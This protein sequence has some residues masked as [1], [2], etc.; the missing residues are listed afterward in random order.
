MN[1]ERGP[2]DR[3][4]SEDLGSEELL[5][6][7]ADRGWSGMSAELKNHAKAVIPWRGPE[8]GVALCVDIRGNGSLVTR[9]SANIEDRRISTKD[10]IWLSPADLPKGEIDI[11]A[12]MAD[13][14]HI[15]LPASPFVSN[16]LDIET[17]GARIGL[18]YEA[19]FEDRTCRRLGAPISDCSRWSADRFAGHLHVGETDP[20]AY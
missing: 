13:V 20:A 7:S 14:L 8:S 5:L 6:S 15:H 12:D 2:L 16:S 3:P 4:V 10:S 11:D 17:T 18:R 1:S 9:R 19:A